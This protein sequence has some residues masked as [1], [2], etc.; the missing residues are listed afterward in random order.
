[1]KKASNT[2]TTTK[3]IFWPYGTPARARA[4]PNTSEIPVAAEALEKNPAKVIATWM[5]DKKR[6]GSCNSFCT[7]LALLLPSSASMVI[8]VLFTDTMAISAQAKK[9]LTAV[10]QS[11]NKSCAPMEPGSGSM[12]LPSKNNKDSAVCGGTGWGV[13]LAPVI[14]T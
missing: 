1:M 3:D 5:V 6:V 9:A 2:V 8:F 7:I 10:R 12:F 13:V 4:A 11:S 14:G